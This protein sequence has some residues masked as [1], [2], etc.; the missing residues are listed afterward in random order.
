MRGFVDPLGSMVKGL[1]R[2]RLSLQIGLMSAVS[3][4]FSSPEEG[5]LTEQRVAAHHYSSIVRL[6]RFFVCRL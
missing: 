1:K 6:L 3:V 2:R 5:R 4:R